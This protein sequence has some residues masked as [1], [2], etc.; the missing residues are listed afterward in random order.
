MNS[1]EKPENA[2]DET[3]EHV[4]A[5]ADAAAQ[6]TTGEP[7]PFTEL[8]N[9]YAE[10]AALKD[11]VL[12]AMAE[13]EN[14]RRRA[15]KEVADARSYGAANFARDMLTF[16]DNLGRALENAPKDAD[17]P[18]KTMIEGVGVIAADFQSRLTRHG[19]KKLEPQGQKFDPNLHEA[20]FEIPDETVPSGTVLQVMEAGYTIGE[21][22]LRPAKVGVSRG[23]P[24]A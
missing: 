11:R 19:V 2:K 6:A 7:E 17:G 4:S 5:L 10:N 23:G 13:V 3:H 20:L 15:E 14:V 18:L 8:E 12:R 9:L 24:K 21:R 22:V 16:A 1:T